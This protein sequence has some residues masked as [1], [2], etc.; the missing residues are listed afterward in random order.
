M[1]G[2]RLVEAL[3][4]AASRYSSEDQ[5]QRG[6]LPEALEG[7]VI[8]N[9]GTPL[10][11]HETLCFL[12][13]Y[14]DDAQILV[15]VDGALETF[16]ARVERLG[17]RAQRRLHDSGVANT[18]LDYPFAFP[19]ARW[20]ARHFPRETEIAWAGF[21]DE[22][23]LDETLSL[24][25]TTA[26][27]DAFSEG[28]MGWRQWLR[29]AKGERRLTDL[30]LLLELVERRGLPEETRDWL[31][32]SLALPILWRPRG[33]GGSRT[34]ARIP[35]DRTFFH[36]EGLERGV[37]DLVVALQQPL[38]LTRAS[39]PLAETMIG[40]AP[41]AMATRQRELHA[42]SYPNADDALV[43]DPRRGLRLV[44]LR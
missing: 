30:Q 26:E 31:F 3:A 17:R 6:A 8:R 19:M 32:E 39:R 4:A 36:E 10:R 43:G 21:A 23:R 9:P 5:K 12:Q 28:G 25:A 27:G 41:A 7:C 29:V 24:L 20:L 38:R 42:F 37:A 34:L 16:P 40:T 15:L 13:A 14:P 33:A 11:L 2:R 44:F 22:D 1:N 35:P 18:T